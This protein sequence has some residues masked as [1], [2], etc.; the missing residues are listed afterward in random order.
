M[1]SGPGAL[2]WD[3]LFTADG[4]RQPLAHVNRRGTTW[5]LRRGGFGSGT[6]GRV[7]VEGEETLNAR[8]RRRARRSGT[9]HGAVVAAGDAVSNPRGTP[10]AVAAARETWR[11]ELSDRARCSGADATEAAPRRELGARNSP[12]VDQRAV[13]TKN[14]RWSSACIRRAVWPM[15]G[16]RRCP[17]SRRSVRSPNPRI[18]RDTPADP[19][20]GARHV[21]VARGA[22]SFW[23]VLAERWKAAAR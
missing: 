14:P 10:S 5:G 9:A 21:L 7:K 20:P 22:R 4:S 13:K 1:E 19:R 8:G 15:R 2:K 6:S 16:R 12:D 11:A 3:G 23:W 17:S 18:A